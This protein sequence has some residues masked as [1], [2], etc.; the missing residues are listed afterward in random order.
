MYESPITQILGEQ[1]I[2]Y[3]NECIKVVQSYGFDV[4]KKELEK[5]LMYDRNQYEKGHKD[6]YED[7]IEKYMSVL[8]DRCVDKRNENYTFECPFCDVYNVAKQL[9]S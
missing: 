1:Q 6:G 9:K 5:A 8:C 7:A 2:T 4:D 3:E